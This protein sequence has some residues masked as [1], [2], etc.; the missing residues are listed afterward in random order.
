MLQPS[1]VNVWLLIPR[2]WSAIRRMLHSHD[3]EDP[4]SSRR[5]TPEEYALGS[6]M[7]KPRGRSPDEAPRQSAMRPTRSR[8]RE[9]AVYVSAGSWQHLLVCGL[10]LT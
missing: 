4:D 8:V 9:G 2:W 5:G 7:R 3:A 6:R 10:W 1:F